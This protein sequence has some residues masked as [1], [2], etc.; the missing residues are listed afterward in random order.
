MS[1]SEDRSFLISRGC[2]RDF[3]PS[4]KRGQL[5]RAKVLGRALLATRTDVNS[6]W[7]LISGNAERG[8]F[9]DNCDDHAGFFY[10]WCLVLLLLVMSYSPMLLRSARLVLRPGIMYVQN[11]MARLILYR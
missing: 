3:S 5:Y 8:P 2:G 10:N 7:M 6:F 9:V 11:G 1:L 4:R